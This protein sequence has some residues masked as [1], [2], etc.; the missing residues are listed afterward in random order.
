M[1]MM[2]EQEQVMEMMVEQVIVMEQEMMEVMVMMTMM[3][4]EEQVMLKEQVM[5]ESL[6]QEVV[7]P[8]IVGH[9]TNDFFRHCESGGGSEARVR[10]WRRAWRD[11]MKRVSE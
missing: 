8:A 2:E 7:A 6:T 10:Q 9:L 5:E 4:M 11:T 3:M 1:V